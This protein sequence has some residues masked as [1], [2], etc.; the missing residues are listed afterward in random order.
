MNDEQIIPLSRFS[1]SLNILKVLNLKKKK[2]PTK[3]KS[4]TIRD[5]NKNFNIP[6]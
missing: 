6:K 3:A 2:K 1:M 4:A 5:I